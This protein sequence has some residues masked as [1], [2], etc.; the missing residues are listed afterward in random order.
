MKIVLNARTKKFE[1]K[2]KK[3]W[4]GLKF[5]RRVEAAALDL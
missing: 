1:C 4:S 2:D 5:E 3:I